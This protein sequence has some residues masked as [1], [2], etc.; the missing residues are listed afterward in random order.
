MKRKHTLENC[1]IYVIKIK[2]M[3]KT[4]KAKKRPRKLIWLDILGNSI[5]YVAIEIQKDW[6]TR[7]K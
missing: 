5:E 7:I 2:M 4:N 1:E 6:R 3:P